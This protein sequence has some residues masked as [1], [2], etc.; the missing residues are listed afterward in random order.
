M[1][2]TSCCLG[3]FIPEIYAGSASCRCLPK[4]CCTWV[5]TRQACSSTTWQITRRGRFSWRRGAA[6]RVAL[7]WSR[8]TRDRCAP[9]PD[10]ARLQ[11]SRAVVKF[12]HR[13]PPGAAGAVHPTSLCGLGD[14]RWHELSGGRA[15]PS[16]VSQDLHPPV[17]RRQVGI[18]EGLF[19]PVSSYQEG[20]KFS[21][22]KL[23]PDLQKNQ[24]I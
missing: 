10:V 2:S 22:Q 18:V 12:P 4:A 23:S 16:W 9:A 20:T 14:D 21:I 7:N 5:W 1:M 11:V 17:Q 15:Q 24:Y 13:L 19:I 8:R 3:G 6:S